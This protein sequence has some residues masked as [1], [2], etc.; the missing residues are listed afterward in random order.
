MKR[1]ILG[2]ALTGVLAGCSQPLD[3]PGRTNHPPTPTP[4]TA[5]ASAQPWSQLHV[6]ADPR[7]YRGPSTAVLPTADIDPIATD[8]H[9]VL[10]ARVTDTQGSHVTVGSV[11]R[12]LALDVYGSLAATVY[13]LGLGSHLVGRDTSTGFPAARSLPLVTRNGHQLNAEA[14]LALHPTV[15]ITDT[16]LGPWNVVLQVRASGVPVVVVDSKRSLGTVGTLVDQVAAAL[17][18]PAE[19]KRLADRLDGGIRAERAQIDSVAPKDPARRLRI[20][21]L[22][23]RGRLGVYYLFGQGTGADSLI[24]ALG[25]VDVATDAGIKGFT[26]LDAEALARTKPDVLLMMTDGL[27]SVGG[28]AGALGL[29]GVAQTPAGQHRRVVDMSDFQLLSFG[30]LTASVLD[31]LARALYAPGSS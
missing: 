26:P 14:I 6:L 19:G 1:L 9:P 5:R 27:A 25:G 16:T 13:G 15:L 31:A 21:F 8:P 11:D 18:V 30:P 23:A 2:L 24:D 22:Y 10:P 7:D 28:V 4:T 29:P 12:I 20:A 3:A 17:G